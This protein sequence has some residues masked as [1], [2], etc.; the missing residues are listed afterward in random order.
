MTHDNS[1]EFAAHERFLR[2]AIAF[3]ATVEQ[4]GQSVRATSIASYKIEWLDARMI[5]LAC[6]G[7]LFFSRAGA[8]GITN[9]SISHRLLLV[10]AF[11]Q[12]TT[13]TESLVSEGQYIKATS[14]LKQDYELLTR[15]RE[16]KAGQAVAG[17]TPNVRHAPEG[18]QR[19]YGELNKIAH[20]S[21]PDLLTQVLAITRDGDSV[22]PSPVPKFAPTTAAS[23]YELHVWL[24]LEVFREQLLLFLELYPNET[25]L[26]PSIMPHFAIAL[27]A[28]EKAGFIFS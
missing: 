27:A 18:S 20:P 21:N 17:Q 11:F 1:S 22:G 10:C 5:L 7:N 16:V 15:I 12:G 26:L 3:E 28:L 19:F 23:L 25:D 13:V 24:I 2:H 6:S 14:A 4:V 8:P 9:S